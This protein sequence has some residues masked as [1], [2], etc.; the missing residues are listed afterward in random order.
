M[1]LGDLI[2]RLDDPDAAVEVLMATGDVG[3][4]AFA[5]SEAAHHADGLGAYL[6]NAIAAFSS[7]ASADDW[8]SAMMVASRSDNPGGAFLGAVI[9]RAGRPVAQPRMGAHDGYG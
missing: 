6:S 9:R 2:A 7:S 8:M 5:Q 4:I 1:M 3:L